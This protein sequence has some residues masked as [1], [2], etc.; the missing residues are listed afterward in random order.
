V[1]K[2]IVNWTN[3]KSDKFQKELVTFEH[4]LAETGLFTDAALINMLDNHP[5]DQL[6]VCTMSGDEHPKY[7]NRM[8]TGDFRDVSGKEILQAAKAGNVWVNVR[9]A[10]NLH[11]EYKKVL[12]EMYGH[13]SELSG[14]KIYNA[15]GGILLS[16]P[17]AKVP[18]HFDKTE[19]L[20][21]HVR[22]K[23]SLFLYPMT[24]EFIPDAAHEAAL[25]N[26]LDEDLPYSK[27]FEEHVQRVDLKEGEAASWRLNAPHRVA[28]ETFCVSVTTEYST[29][30]SGMKNAVMV[31]NSI[32]RNKL[33]LSP[34][35]AKETAVSKQ[36]KSVFGRVIKKSG[37]LPDTAPP[38][39]VTFKIDPS[40]PGYLVDV[41]P[42]ERNF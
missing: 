17:I 1:S 28:N 27:N 31:T 9:R 12:D 14:R 15:K 40:A 38:D 8:R 18:Y 39:M 25:T 4:R 3:Q 22:G 13:L 21:W 19:T 10:M 23:K 30:E 20:L 33:G 2:M 26:Y 35:Y 5:S 36:V 6:D 34:E 24:E 7:P 37:L 41:Q 29:R 42:F 11:P 32:L 16:S